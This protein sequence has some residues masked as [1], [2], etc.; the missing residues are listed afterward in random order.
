MTQTLLDAGAKVTATT[1]TG[2]TPLH[3]AAKS[4]SVG[5][6]EVLIEVGA[7]IEVRESAW[8]QT[9]L[10]F[11]AGFNRL[12]AVEA[13]LERGADPSVREDVVDL[14]TRY[15]VDRAARAARNALLQEFRGLSPQP[16]DVEAVAEAGAGCCRG[17][18]RRS[19]PCL[20]K[21]SS[22]AFEESVGPM[23]NLGP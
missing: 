18:D 5:A 20:P 14:P 11:A 1:T 3:L 22:P 23:T 16:Y 21:T 4:G 19:R 13:L 8:G 10:I 7:D 2:V 17:R 12:E 6:V 15:A 9:P